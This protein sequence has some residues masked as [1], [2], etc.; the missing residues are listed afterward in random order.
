MDVTDK[1]YKEEVL[2]FEGVVLVDF[3]ATWCTP[4]KIQGPIIDEL[5]E[6]YKS[7]PNVKFAK[8]DTDQN[9]DTSMANQIFS[10]PTLILYK[11]GEIIEK[12]VGLRSSE[13]LEKKIQEL[14]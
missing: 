7:N 11:R 3:W 6:K 5:A 13:E 8:L 10:I 4:C 14:L 2:D 9:P 12:I 1:T